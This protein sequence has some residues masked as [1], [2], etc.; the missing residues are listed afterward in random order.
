M[1]QV[2]SIEHFITKSEII[3]LISIKVNK[4]CFIKNVANLS[5]HLHKPILNQY[6]RKAKLVI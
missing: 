5:P 4:M 3:I 1:F 6:D 2:F